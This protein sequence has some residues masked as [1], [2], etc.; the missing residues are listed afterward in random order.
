LHRT[1]EEQ[2]AAPTAALAR[3]RDTVARKAEK[4]AEL[5]RIE[6]RLLADVSHDVRAPLTLILGS[7]RDLLDGKKGLLPPAA[8]ESLERVYRNAE[9]VAGLVEQILGTA[10]LD[11]RDARPRLPLA[12]GVRPTDEDLRWLER[13][14]EEIETGSVE[15]GFS[16]EVLADR[17][18]VHRSRLH[19]RLR[20]L[21]G[22]P[23]VQ[24]IIR[25]RLERA[26][27]LLKNGSASVSEAAYAVGFQSLEHFS[28]TFRKH[29]GQAPSKYRRGGSL[30][31]DPLP[32]P[33]E[34]LPTRHQRL[35]P[36]DQAAHA[37]AQV[38]C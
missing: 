18:A 38:F 20:H 15:E 22:L 33:R 11:D 27:A 25:W 5:D 9:R 31:R 29:Y 28:R 14:R 24:L 34:V 37:G 6:S 1:H 12:P 35:P 23:P 16:V 7:L 21:I 17:L 32:A 26:A 2:V 3:E 13:V 36:K 8:V 10:R 19:E 30:P 4:L